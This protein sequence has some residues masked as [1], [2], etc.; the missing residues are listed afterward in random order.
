V[1]LE[2][3]K[4]LIA[5][6]HQFRYFF[7]AHPR[8]AVGQNHAFVIIVRHLIAR[9]NETVYQLVSSQ[10]KFLNYRAI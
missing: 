6:D 1:F 5:L 10:Q 8:H 9:T 4:S 3:E 7:V 2:L